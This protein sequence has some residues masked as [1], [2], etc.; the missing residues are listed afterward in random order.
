MKARPHISK[1]HPTHS[2]P[3][4]LFNT[5]NG[6]EG[7]FF[8]LHATV[9]GRNNIRVLDGYGWGRE[10]SPDFFPSP[11]STRVKRLSKEEER[12]EE[13][14]SLTQR[15]RE[16]RKGGN[17]KRELLL[18]LFLLLLF[19]QISESSSSD[20]PVRSNAHLKRGISEGF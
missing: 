1:Q 7:P 13:G 19:G 12:R 18:F 4:P 14:M 8:S 11:I 6:K 2:S 16:K 15:R 3:P 20:S 17:V 9:R 10:G 5:R